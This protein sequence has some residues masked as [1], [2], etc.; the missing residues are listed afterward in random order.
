MYT[1]KYC[2]EKFEKQ[3]SLAAHFRKCK[4]KHIFLNSKDLNDLVKIERQLTCLNC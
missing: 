3:Q 1:C 4:E 2:G